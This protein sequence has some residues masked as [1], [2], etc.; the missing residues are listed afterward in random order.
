M[1]LSPFGGRVFGG[2]GIGAVFCGPHPVGET[3]ESGDLFGKFVQVLGGA[4]L[5]GGLDGQVDH[6]LWRRFAVLL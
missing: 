1:A 2:C 6:I 5:I 3:A 4:R